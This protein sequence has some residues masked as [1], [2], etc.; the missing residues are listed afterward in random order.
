MSCVS[1]SVGCS[2]KVA[3]DLVLNIGAIVL[4]SK[5]VR[6]LAALGRNRLRADLR[7]L[8]LGDAIKDARE[9]VVRVLTDLLRAVWIVV[10][11]SLGSAESLD[12]G[13]IARAAR[14]DDRAARKDGELDR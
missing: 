9:L 10:V 5:K 12:E 8:A 14:R 1:V 13:E 3:T 2:W 7:R 11:E 4:R 6:D